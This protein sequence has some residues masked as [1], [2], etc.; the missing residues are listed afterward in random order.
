MTIV[1][2][3]DSILM[4]YSYA[5]FPERSFALFER[6]EPPSEKSSLIENERVSQQSQQSNEEG[7]GAPL[8]ADDLLSKRNYEEIE[9]LPVATSYPHRN[10][11]EQEDSIIEDPGTSVMDPPALLSMSESE[12]TKRSLIVKQNTMSG[13]SIILTLISILVAFRQVSLIIIFWA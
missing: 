6:R 3:A 10:I 12:E 13:L 7:F 4:L 1:D 5:G 8:T 11:G 2:S 9:T